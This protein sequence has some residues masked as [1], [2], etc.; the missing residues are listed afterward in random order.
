M[1]EDELQ[2]QQELFEHHRFTV[3][4][5]QSLLRIDKYLSVRLVNVS[6]TRVQ[7]AAQAGNIIVNNVPVKSSYKVNQGIIY[8]FSCLNL[9]GK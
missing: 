1:S 6:R 2:D 4:Q 7:S 8:R 5:G 3:D 9:Q